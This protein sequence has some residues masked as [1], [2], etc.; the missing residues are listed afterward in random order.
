M[1]EFKLMQIVP[2]LNSGGVEQGAIDVANSL[3][4]KMYKNFIISNGGRMV[5]DLNSKF[6]Y[7]YNLP[8][9]S[10]NFFF[11][12]YIAFR[13]NKLIKENKVNILHIRS[14]A[15]AWLLPFIDKKNIKTVSTFHNIYGHNNFFKKIYNKGLSKTN[16][17]VAISQY[18]CEEI[19]L[20]YNLNPEKIVIINRGIDTNFYNPKI[21][22]K[23]NVKNFKKKINI[24][25]N[26]KIIIYPG[27]VTE[28]KG[29]LEF[30]NVV[31]N[32]KNNEY[33][34][35]F[36]GDTKNKK[37]TKKLTNEIKKNKLD[38]CKILGH[39]NKNELKS[40]YSLCDLVI[41][42]PLKPEGF[43]RV[44]GESLAMKKIILAYNFG[45]VKNQ[46]DGLDDLY[47]IKCFDQN[48]LIKKIL[49]SLSFSNEKLIKIKEEG[50]KNVINFFSKDQML[51]KYINLY[52]D[53]SF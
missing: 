48:Q 19:I 13:I 43:G 34:F 22:D 32:F 11:F 23:L 42:A 45:G 27:R 40:M 49:E 21:F 36:I 14:R 10:K 51:Q 41:S 24:P 3:A 50:R 9:H 1:K 28:W 29:Q 20:N 33:M 44:I 30:L 2:A 53:I 35:Y 31:N 8:V 17:I 26:K 25:D 12:P 47:K 46:L 4:N 52:E 37:Y 16:H 18:V 39:L 7:H 6:V 5:K 15:P 38:N